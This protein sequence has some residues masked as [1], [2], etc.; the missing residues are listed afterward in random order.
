MTRRSKTAAA[1]SPARVPLAACLER[2]K[3]SGASTW[4]QVE[5]DFLATMFGFDQLVAR[6]ETS[7][8]D[9]QNGKGDFFNDLLVVVL[10]AASGKKIHSRPDIKGLSFPKHKL[11][12]AYPDKGPVRW[13]IETKATG[14][15]KHPGNTAQE[16]PGGRAGSADLDKR[17]KEAA[18]KNIDIKGETARAV[19]KGGG[20]TSDLSSWLKQAPPQCH[21]FLS[22]RVRDEADLAKTL[23]F[24]GIA[25]V[26]FDS[27]GLFAYGL[28]G[29]SDGYEAKE[30]RAP[31][32]ELDRVLAPV[33][34]SLRL[35]A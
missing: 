3:Q 24:A 1:K 16:H 11:D 2:A 8:G 29:A 14:I 20:A 25:S 23:R 26:W 19:G 17:I 7:Q 5:E 34:T 30:L 15:P 13:T 31:Q 21:L 4:P 28:N 12:I 22:V 18:L 27:V 9:R 33:A 6:G 10:E 32:W 35:M